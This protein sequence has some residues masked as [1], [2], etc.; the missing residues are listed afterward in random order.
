MHLMTF[1]SIEKLGSLIKIDGSPGTR[2]RLH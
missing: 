1:S 2:H